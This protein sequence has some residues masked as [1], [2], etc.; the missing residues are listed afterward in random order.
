MRLDRDSF[1]AVLRAHRERCNISL[2]QL[3]VQTKV[4]REIWRAL[5]ENDFSRWPRR[6]YARSLIRQYARA[7]GLNPEE[8]VNEFCRLFQQGDRRAETLLQE[9]A[10]VFGHRLDLRREPL[11]AHAPHERRSDRR[12]AG[13]A[14]D[15]R[16]GSRPD[17]FRRLRRSDF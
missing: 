16:V 2:A 14:P 12:S 11:P 9:C 17:P 7:I 6:I 8:V 4:R 13:A 10:A 3:S 1:G 15:G 5:E